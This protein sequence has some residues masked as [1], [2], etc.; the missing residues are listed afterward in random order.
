MLKLIFKLPVSSET[1]DAN[2]CIYNR[3]AREG[4]GESELEWRGEKLVLL[5]INVK[6]NVMNDRVHV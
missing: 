3:D 1:I 2:R 4:I 6:N 5:G